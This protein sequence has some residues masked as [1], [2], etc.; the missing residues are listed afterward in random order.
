M[1]GRDS[2]WRRELHQ[3]NSRCN[4]FHTR[5]VAAKTG[6]RFNTTRRYLR[7]FS[8]IGGVRCRT[9]LV[10][11]AWDAS[12]EA[13]CS[14]LQLPNC[15]IGLSVSTFKTNLKLRN[16]LVEKYIQNCANILVRLDLAV[17]EFQILIQKASKCN[18]SSVFSAI[19]LDSSLLLDSKV[20]STGAISR[21]S[22]KI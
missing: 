19:S 20:C 9:G 8:S 16:K 6:S 13:N 7:F 14:L 12:Q 15:T 17:Q 11:L 21:A 4:I 18:F 3:R 10:A 5:S 2:S 22:S 1:K